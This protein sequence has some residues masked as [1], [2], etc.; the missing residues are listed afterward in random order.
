MATRKIT[1][2]K[3]AAPPA[4]IEYKVKVSFLDGC[5]MLFTHDQ[6]A[7]LV[8]RIMAERCVSCRGINA[9]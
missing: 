2:P 7:E 9:R 4:V 5:E 8:A 1:K 6:Y 3:A